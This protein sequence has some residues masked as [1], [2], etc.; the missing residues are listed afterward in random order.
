MVVAEISIIPMGTETTSVSRYV[1]AAVKEIE[2]SGLKCS[3]GPMGTMIEADSIDEVYA[4]IAR[5]QAAVFDLGAG[6]AYTILKIDERRDVQDRSM[7][8]MVRSAEEG[9]AA[10]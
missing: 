3:L 9:I 4:A 6:R 2:A 1:S 10:R 7:E 8:D 5:A